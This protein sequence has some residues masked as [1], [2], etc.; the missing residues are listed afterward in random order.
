MKRCPCLELRYKS[1]D[2]AELAD[3][4]E[5][6]LAGQYDHHLPFLQAHIRQYHQS[7]FR[8]KIAAYFDALSTNK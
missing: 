5:A 3:K 8:A 2:A 1:G 4:I 7:V 6:A